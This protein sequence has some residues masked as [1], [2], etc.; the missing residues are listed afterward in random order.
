[1]ASSTNDGI[2]SADVLKSASAVTYAR[3]RARMSA[4]TSMR[5]TIVFRRREELRRSRR[6]S[7]VRSLTAMLAAP[8]LT[9]FRLRALLLASLIKNLPG[10]P[11]FGLFKPRD[12]GLCGIDGTRETLHTEGRWSFG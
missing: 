8:P 3:N 2:L 12:G 9:T 10:G 5:E 11:K 7:S 4:R 6:I 1:M